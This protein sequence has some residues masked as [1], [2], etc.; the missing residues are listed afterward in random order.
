MVHVRALPGAPGFCGD[1]QTVLTAAIADAK[2]LAAG[3]AD[4]VMIEN[5]FDTPFPRDASP[6]VTVS[7]LTAVAVA[8]AAE[9][10]LPLGINLLRNDSIGALAVAQAC[11]AKF[12]RVNVLSGTRITDQGMI[13]GEAY[14]LLRERQRCGANRI[15]IAADV[16]VKHSSPV[17]ARPIEEEALELIERAGADALIVS[18]SA[19]GK[20]TDVEDLLRV[21]NACVDAFI[22]VGSG[23]QKDNVRQLAEHC[24]AVIVGSSLKAGD[25]IDSPVDPEKVASLVDCLR[26]AS[27]PKA[28]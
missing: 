20:A 15:G 6:P 17:T 9:V 13:H 10:S 27:G 3:G 18:G 16:D 19:T 26:F 24:D 8:V 22:M 14:A 1:F 28:R 23:V 2:S 12:I 25:R 7:H 5:F 11:G 21:R 4:A